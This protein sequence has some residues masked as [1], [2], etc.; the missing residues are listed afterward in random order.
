MISI[1]QL[2]LN[3]RDVGGVLRDAA[4][5]TKA[6]A[7]TLG[8]VANAA[9]TAVTAVVQSS[10]MASAEVQA[11]RLAICEGCEILIRP[12]MQC[13]KT[14]GGCNCIVIGKVKLAASTCPLGKW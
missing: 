12:Q 4:T 7:I 6:N 2:M 10:P 8:D 13:D 9:K 1:N 11:Q 3:I 14:R 5:A